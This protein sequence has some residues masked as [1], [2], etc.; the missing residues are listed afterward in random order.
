MASGE[1]SASPSRLRN[2][3]ATLGI[4]GRSIVPLR[5]IWMMSSTLE[6][7][8]SS[9]VS[10]AAASA[11]ESAASGESMRASAP[12]TDLALIWWTVCLRCR[13]SPGEALVHESEF[14]P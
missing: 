4:C 12:R 10:V 1:T 3:R 6:P 9:P 14:A 13:L 11:D 2:S 5:N 7:F 8:S